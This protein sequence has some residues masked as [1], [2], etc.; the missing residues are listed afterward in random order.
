MSYRKIFDNCQF[1][2][3]RSDDGNIRLMFGEEYSFA[4]KDL[5]E[6]NEFLQTLIAEEESHL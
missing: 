6:L 5:R 2:V 4:L 1:Q 3:E